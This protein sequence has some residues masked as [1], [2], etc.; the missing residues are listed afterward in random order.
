MT[1]IV[2]FRQQKNNLNDSKSKIYIY[3]V[4]GPKGC[5]AL[6]FRTSKYWLILTGGCFLKVVVTSS[7]TASDA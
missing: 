1:K 5:E 4:F 3:L 7:L 2:E 6:Q